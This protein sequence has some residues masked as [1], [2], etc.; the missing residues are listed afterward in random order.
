MTPHPDTSPAAPGR[1]GE[2]PAVLRP[3]ACSA[4]V[5]ARPGSQTWTITLPAGLATLSLNDHKRHWAEKNRRAQALRK[6]AWAMALQA[7]VPPLE[8]GVTIAVEYQPPDRRRRDNENIP[9]ASGKHCIDGLVA[10][11][12]L[13]DDAPPHVAAVTGTIGEPYPGGRFILRV[14]GVPRA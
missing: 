14:T 12:V 7:R 5:E 3:A 4:G 13:A 11:K 6:A 9:I 10:A 1:E 8:P 2:G